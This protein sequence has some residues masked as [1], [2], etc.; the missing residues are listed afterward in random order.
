MKEL[1]CGCDQK[2]GDQRTRNAAGDPGPDHN[3]H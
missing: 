1:N 2:D 3:Q